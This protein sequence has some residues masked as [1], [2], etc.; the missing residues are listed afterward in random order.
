MARNRKQFIEEEIKPIKYRNCLYKMKLAQYEVEVNC[1]KKKE[2][3]QL[4]AQKILKVNIKREYFVIVVNC[5]TLIIL[6]AFQLMHPHIQT[7]G[8]ILRLYG[9]RMD[10]T[11]ARNENEPTSGANGSENNEGSLK[12]VDDAKLNVSNANGTQ[13]SQKIKP[14]NELLEKLKEEMRKLRQRTSAAAAAASAAAAVVEAVNDNKPDAKQDDHPIVG[15]NPAETLLTIPPLILPNCNEMKLI[16][17]RQTTD[18]TVTKIED[19]DDG[20]IVFTSSA[21]KQDA[22]EIELNPKRKRHTSSDSENENEFEDD[23]ESDTSS[24]GSS[25]SSSSASSSSSSST[26]SDDDD[27]EEDENDSDDLDTTGDFDS[28]SAKNKNTSF[29]SNSLS[30]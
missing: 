11:T 29:H 12:N 24:E 3:R 23:D 25:S 18:N 26:S 13:N 30:D 8:S 16:S 10:E 20:M 19:N 9:S 22:N 27:D 15:P 4:A 14:N 2:G 21:T 28:H 5:V 6:S 1:T 17:N 7:W